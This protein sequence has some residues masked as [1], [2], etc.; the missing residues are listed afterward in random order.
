V[1]KLARETIGSTTHNTG[2]T[3]P[4]GTGRRRISL[5]G[6]GLAPRVL[7][8]RVLAPELE[9]DQ[10]AAEPEHGQAEV[11]LELSPVAAEPEHGPVE[12]ALELSPV[13]AERER[14]RAAAELE[15]GPV[16]AVPELDPLAVLPK[17]KSVT[18]VHH[19]GLVRV[20]KKAEDLA[21]VAAA[22][23]HAAAVAEA[24]TAW[25]AAE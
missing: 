2:A 11:A 18:A 13:A 8:S 21:A 6:R 14:A 25:A 19:R 9:H 24:A 12:V 10:V 7:G 1:V 23:M 16:A 4:M 5:V 20:P 22:T 17:N 15:H 3:H